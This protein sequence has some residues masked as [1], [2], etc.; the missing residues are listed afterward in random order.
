[1]AD[2]LSGLIERLKEFAPSLTGHLSPEFASASKPD[3]R[4]AIRRSI[5]EHLDLLAKEHD[6][7]DDLAR[8][9]SLNSWSVSISHCTGA[10]GW[11]AVPAP[12]RIGLDLE[13]RD[14]I[15]QKLIDRIAQ[16]RELEG[17][18]DASFL[19]CAKEAYFKALTKNQPVA[20]T[21]LYIDSWRPAGDR[22]FTFIGSGENRGNGLILSSG[23]HLV[24]ICII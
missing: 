14:R 9:P 11:V 10:G 13:M 17:I 15:Q 22:A 4:A 19:W 21:Q 6:H 20:I 5:R 2:H 1:M 24:S 16:P 3:H 23:P 12:S 8:P 7:V 18:P